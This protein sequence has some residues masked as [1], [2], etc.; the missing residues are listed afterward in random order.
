MNRANRHQIHFLVLLISLNVAFVH[1]VRLAVLHQL[2]LCPQLIIC[3]LQVLNEL[4]LSL[5][6]NHLLV[7][8]LL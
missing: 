1:Q 2:K 7:D 4:V 6:H 5:H 8:F 3:F